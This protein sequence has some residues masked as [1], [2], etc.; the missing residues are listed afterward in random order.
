LNCEVNGKEIVLGSNIRVSFP[1]EVK[2]VINFDEVFVC[3]LEPG[4]ENMNEN[5]FCFSQDG[6]ILWKIEKALSSSESSPYV[7][8]RKQRGK[9]IASNWS[10][11]NVCVKLEDG[12]I[13][14]RRFTK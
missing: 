11:F 2:K 4:E 1:F 6:R 13:A 7:N 12:K 5:I 9:L 10:G 8:I 3:L 14:W